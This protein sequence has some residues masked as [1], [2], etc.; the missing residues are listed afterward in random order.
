MTST[1]ETGQARYWAREHG[2]R[3]RSGP[4]L[5]QPIVTQ[6]ARGQ[7]VEATAD[8]AILADGYHWLPIR[9]GDTTAFVALELLSPQSVR[10]DPVGPVPVAPE[11]VTAAQGTPLAAHTRA[12]MAIAICESGARTARD[13]GG[14]LVHRFEPLQWDRL[15]RDSWGEPPATWTPEKCYVTSWGVG[16]IMGWAHATFNCAD[17]LAFRTWLQA[18]PAHEYAALVR[19]CLTKPGVAGALQ[20]ESWEQLWRLYNGGHPQWLP[21]FQSALQRV[22]EAAGGP[23]APAPRTAV[24]GPVPAA[25]PFTDARSLVAPLP[26]AAPAAADF[27]GIPPAAPASPARLTHRAVTVV[28]PA[29][30]GLRYEGGRLLRRGLMLVTLVFTLWQTNVI[31]PA[32]IVALLEEAVVPLVTDQTDSVEGRLG[33]SLEALEARLTALEQVAPPNMSLPSSGGAGAALPVPNSTPVPT[34]APE[35]TATPLPP[36]APTPE[37]TASLDLTPTPLAA[38]APTAPPAPAEACG[39]RQTVLTARYHV[40]AAPALEAAVVAILG[41]GT[42]VCVL[43]QQSG[44]SRL[45]EPEGWVADAGLAPLPLAG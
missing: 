22:V 33:H 38:A 32:Q 30:Q 26:D 9:Q 34:A 20:T 43:T 25:P 10:P 40:R 12:L 31:S 17:A 8:P 4:G 23:E 2:V 27:S 37:P 7:A 39:P 19:F 42:P 29:L 1:S 28:R 35:P 45:R 18:D 21:H 44:W 3:V 16:Q 11:L 6:L 14:E 13:N 15:F 5:Q 24:Q 41:P 36:P